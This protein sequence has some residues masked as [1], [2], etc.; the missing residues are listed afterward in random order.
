MFKKPY[1][2]AE[3]GCNHMGNMEIAHELINTATYFC[4]VDAIK[5]QKRCPK[6]L[7]TEEQYNAPHPIDVK[8][9]SALFIPK[10]CKHRLMTMGNAFRT[11]YAFLR[12]RK[13]L[14]KTMFG[15]EL[16]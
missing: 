9:G 6:E 12:K 4:K 8:C 16:G 14:L 11:L 7:L 1:V 3:A 5:L 15:L 13:L 2:I 10:G